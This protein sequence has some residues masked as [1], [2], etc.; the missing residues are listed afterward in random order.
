MVCLLVRLEDEKGGQDLRDVQRTQEYQL[1]F[2]RWRNQKPE[3]SARR[4]SETAF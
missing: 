1:K 4:R 3:K 2:E